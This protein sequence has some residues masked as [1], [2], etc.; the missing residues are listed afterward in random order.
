[1]LFDFTEE[2]WCT[3]LAETKLRDDADLV[4][5]ARKGDRS[6]F[7]TLYARHFSAVFGYFRARVLASHDAEDMAQEVFVRIYKALAKFD[8]DQ[9]FRPWAL[10]IA[11][12]VLREFIRK[13]HRRGEVAWS[14]LC[15]DLEEQMEEDESVFEDILDFVPLCMNEINES[16]S[17]ALKSHYM[18]GRKVAEIA[19]HMGRTLGAVK[20]LMVRAR[21]AL[22]RCIQ[23]YT[24]SQQR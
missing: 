7:A 16:G 12:N 21:Q 23:G 20:V 4:L 11:R 14:E 19:D 18:G 8:T 17:E 22:K 15:L 9:L 3:A 13:K 24:K 5:A 2:V 10:G 1:M 6:G